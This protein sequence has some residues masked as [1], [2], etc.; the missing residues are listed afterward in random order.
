MSVPNI[1]SIDQDIPYG[2]I[3]F[4]KAWLTSSNEARIGLVLPD[5]RSFQ[6]VG[7][8][9]YAYVLGSFL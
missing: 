9:V 6:V 4:N 3:T 2:I 1:T 8:G 7:G 5:P